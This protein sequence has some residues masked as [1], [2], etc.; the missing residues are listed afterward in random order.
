MTTPDIAAIIDT[1]F[2]TEYLPLDAVREA[3]DN[4]HA[5]ART[6]GRQTP[7]PID[8]FEQACII[9]QAVKKGELN[10]TDDA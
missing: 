8:A 1:E 3:Y 7:R 10:A 2:V 9:V 5:N 6:E 4:I